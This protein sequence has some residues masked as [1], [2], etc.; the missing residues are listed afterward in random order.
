MLSQQLRRARD[1]VVPPGI[2]KSCSV[3][4]VYRDRARDEHGRQRRNDA[5]SCVVCLKIDVPKS[6]KQIRKQ[7]SFIATDW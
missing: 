5:T 3:G 7:H 1:L 2:G 6:N 4:N